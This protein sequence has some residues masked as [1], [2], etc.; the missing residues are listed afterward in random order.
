M[1]WKI[2]DIQATD[3]LITSAKYYVQIVV[4]GYSADTEGY[5]H[6]NEPKISKA[7]D[8]VVEADVIGWIRAE[9]QGS[10]EQRLNDQ[11]AAL[12]ADRKV[13]APWLPQTFTPEV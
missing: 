6:F 2:T 5:W 13:V 11:I 7:F 10:I 1:N 9:S 4:D 12:A 8:E 3:G